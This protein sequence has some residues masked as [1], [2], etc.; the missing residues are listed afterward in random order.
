MSFW[1]KGKEPERM[2]LEVLKSEDEKKFG[3]KKKHFLD[4]K[5]VEKYRFLQKS[6]FKEYNFLSM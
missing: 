4:W 3:G 1:P 2:T 6:Y 5:K